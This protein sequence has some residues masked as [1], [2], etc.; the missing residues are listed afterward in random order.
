MYHRLQV[1]M[2]SILQ[3]D[4]GFDKTNINTVSARYHTPQNFPSTW[5]IPQSIFLS[6]FIMTCMGYD[7]LTISSGTA[8]PWFTVRIPYLWG[9]LMKQ[10]HSCLSRYLS[11]YQGQYGEICSNSTTEDEGAN[12]EPQW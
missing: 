2:C 5:N 8:Y 1:A 3:N 11:W 10:C 7:I 4:M 9:L 12:T 6:S